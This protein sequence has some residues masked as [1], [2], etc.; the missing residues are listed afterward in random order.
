VSV[1]GLASSISFNGNDVADD[2]AL[3]F[4][5]LEDDD[6][7]VRL[8]TATEDIV[9][10]LDTD[11]ELAG[12]GPDDGTG[13]A[14]AVT[15]TL[16]GGPLASGTQLVIERSTDLDQE[17]TFQPQGTFSPIVHSRMADKLTLIAQDL[18]RRVA[19]LE[20][21]GDLVDFADLAAAT[22]GIIT[23]QDIAVDAD[24]P[25]NTFPIVIAMANGLNA[26]LLL[27]GRVWVKADPDTRLDAVG[28]P[29]WKPG[30][31]AN[32]I[33]LLNLPGLAPGVTYTLNALV[34]F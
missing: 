9:L 31:G 5:V 17:T 22:A 13:T 24:A 25:E 23:G 19:A 7:T 29:T 27:I 1:T 21:L 3:P 33:T 26:K 30:P 8:V 4:R 2:F 28:L 18:D 20:A 14:E 15:L 12:V 11:Y 34:T 10:V 32:E 6:L 16:L